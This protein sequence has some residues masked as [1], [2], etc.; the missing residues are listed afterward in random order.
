MLLDTNA[1][2]FFLNGDARVRKALHDVI[3]NPAAPI[4]I[5]AASFWEMTIKH[6]IGKLPLPAPFSSDPVKAMT[7]WCNRAAIQMLDLAP[8]YIGEAM[9]LSF[10]HDDPFDRVIA[11]TALA[12]GLQLVT[13]DRRFATCPGLQVVKI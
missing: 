12:E 8:R 9:S 5:S 10:S 4:K 11:A 6:R 13:S 7:G 2:L 3:T 1:F